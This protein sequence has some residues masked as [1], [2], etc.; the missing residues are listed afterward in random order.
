MILVRL[1]FLRVIT[2][3]CLYSQ[4]ALDASQSP[5]SEIKN[6]DENEQDNK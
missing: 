4:G 5:D 1:L 6:G 2:L 3:R